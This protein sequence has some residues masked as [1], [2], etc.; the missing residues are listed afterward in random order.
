MKK[1]RMVFAGAMVLAGMIA[2]CG[3]LGSTETAAT[4]PTTKVERKDLR[5]TVQSQGTVSSNRDVDIK[6]KVSGT[7]LELPYKDVSGD[8]KPGELLLRLDG[9]DP[10]TALRS[11]QAVVDADQAKFNEAVLTKQI[12]EKQLITD[13]LKANAN[14]ASARA[15]EADAKAKAARTQQLFENNL[16]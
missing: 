15:K 10:D 13:T 16:A 14:L 9:R 3:K 12:A 4:Q 11:A 7:I 2:A 1:T 5:V 8:V 6:C